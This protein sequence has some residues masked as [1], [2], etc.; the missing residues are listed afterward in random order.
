ALAYQPDHPYLMNYL[1]YGWADQGIRLEESLKMLKH[2]ASLKP[3][4]GYITDSLGW[5]YYMIGHYNDAVPNLE[6]A[7]QFLPYDSTINEHLG[8]AYWR[9]GRRAEAKFQWERA[10]NYSKN[11]GQIDMLMQKIAN[12]LDSGPSTKRAENQLDPRPVN[13]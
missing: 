7:V 12:G 11:A 13:R 10:K 3:D 4:D 1:A 5:T 2:A 9:V 8:D 6:N